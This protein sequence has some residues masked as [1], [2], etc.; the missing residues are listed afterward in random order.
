M[1]FGVENRVLYIET[2]DKT[3][4]FSNG[5]KIELCDVDYEDMVI[6]LDYKNVVNIMSVMNGEETDFTTRFAYVKDQELGMIYFSNEDN[7][8]KFYLMSKIDR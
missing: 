2:S 8:Q 5:I 7:S 1:Y 6:C 3:N 4:R